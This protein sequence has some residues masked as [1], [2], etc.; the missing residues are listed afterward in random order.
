MTDWNKVLEY[1]E[2]KMPPYCPEEPSLT[3]KVFLRSYSL[4]A[5]FGGAAGGGKAIYTSNVLPTPNGFVKMGDIKPGDFIFGR[6]GEPH[7]VL[8]ESEIM[9]KNG[10]KLTFD[11]GSIVDACDEHLW[12]TYNA[13]ELE[14]LTKRTP[15]FREKR[16]AKR[17]SRATNSQGEYKSLAIAERNAINKPET[18]DA[19]TGTVRTTTEIVA[20]LLTPRGRRNHAVPVAAPINLPHKNL[21]IDPYV[22]G[23]WLGDGSSAT[24]YICGQDEQVFTNVE[25]AYSVKSTKYTIPNNLNFKV[26]NFN[27]LR[28]D[29][30]QL[31]LLKNKHVPHDYLWASEEQRVALLQ[32]LMDTDGTVAKNSGAAEFCNTNKA[33]VDGLAFL[34]RSLG[35]KTTI[36]E[37]RA[38]LNGKDCGPKWTIKFVANRPVFRLNR[39]LA[40]QKIA[41]R[42]TT[43]FRYI[44]SAERTGPLP[45]KCI[46]VS[47]PDSLYLVS[48]DFIPTHNSSALLMSAMQYVDTPG[49]SAIIFRRTYADLALPGAIMDRFM[50]WM[51]KYDD[52]RWNG[53]NYTA[54]FPSGAR[55][56]FGYLNNQQDY[57]R[58][59]GAEFQFIGMDEVT[60]I[61]ENDYR[62]MF[63]RL[64][65]PATGPLAQ[66]PLRMRSACNPAPN[67]VRQ[68]FIVEGTEK[69]RIF[70]PSKLTDNPGI[71]ADS[72]RQA[73]QALDPVER[74]RLEEGDW[75]ATTLGTMFD[76]TSIILL[77]QNDMPAITSTARAVRFWDLAATEPSHSNPNPDWTVGTLMLFDQG[78]AYILD[79]KKARV[80]GEKV[81]QLIAQTAYEDGR[82]VAVRMEQE[83]GSSGKA[84]VDQYARYVL[85]GHDFGGIRSTGD[86][87]TRARPFA[88]AV[89][90]GN[91]R[92]LRAPW[93]TDWMDELSSFPESCDHDDQVDSA[94]GAFTHLTGL[95]LPQRK[96][97]G[98][99]I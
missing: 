32:G 18:L 45:M 27:G 52:V 2:P 76:R 44:V 9:Q 60:E 59:K 78:I 28:Q 97:I 85:P 64:R 6:D 36:R 90:N 89:A 39:K 31:G 51:A 4:E 66:V 14:A 25:L 13:R 46:R 43:Q 19:P 33:I 83:P 55:L 87:V 15:E 72:Y 49:Y 12:L 79:V 54:V 63:S 92:C 57:L 7:L 24:G 94:V 67:W 48:E 70:V 80:R 93:L 11:D 16:R 81:E 75:W 1:L 61:R 73:L 26:V 21:L 5:L 29:L 88:A 37:G 3:Q 91:I 68:R 53:N 42:R 10:Y 30:K 50:N 71:D 86:K 17:P 98:I 34:V 84:L 96:R 20:T 77:D 65:R 23:A 47:S 62:Y 8:A 99:I 41:S 56:S 82:L 22:L 58:Y 69:G 38:K 40:L 74:K 95:G 35:M